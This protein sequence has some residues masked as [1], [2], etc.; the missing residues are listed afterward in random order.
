[1]LILN[2][3]KKKNRQLPE[4]HKTQIKTSLTECT[5]DDLRGNEYQI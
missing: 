2:L 3:L 4:N 1:M 5:S